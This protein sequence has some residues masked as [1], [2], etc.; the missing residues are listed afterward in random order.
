MIVERKGKKE[1]S[2]VEREGGQIYDCGKG[3]RADI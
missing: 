1:V 2:I 3:R